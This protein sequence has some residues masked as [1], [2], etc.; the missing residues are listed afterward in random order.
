M[1]AQTRM[2]H[3]RRGF[4][5][6]EL[7][8]TLALVGIVAIGAFS[9][10]GSVSTVFS[11]Q[12][13]VTDAQGNLR[14]ALDVIQDDAKSAGYLGTANMAREVS[15]VSN[16]DGIC[17]N[18]TGLSM[19]RISAVRI[20]N[21][22]PGAYVFS[23][24]DNV[25]IEPDS[26]TL[27]GAFS[28]AEALPIATVVN[29]TLNLDP[30]EATRIFSGPTAAAN[31]AIFT[32][33]FRPRRLVRVWKPG[34]PAQLTFIVSAA[35]QDGGNPVVQLNNLVTSGNAQCGTEGVAA[36]GYRVSVLEIVRYHLVEDPSDERKANLMRTELDPTTG[37]TLSIRIGNSDFPNSVAVAEYVVDFQVW[38]D[39]DV[40]SD[41][42]A[43]VLP[44]IGPD[45]IGDDEGGLRFDYLEGGLP[46]QDHWHRVRVLHI[47][48]AVRT[49]REDPRWLHRQRERQSG[50]NDGIVYGTLFSV[51]LNDNNVGAARVVSMTTSVEVS[52]LTFRNL[53]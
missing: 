35:W 51:N 44:V 38:A 8:V 2:R 11:V 3:D 27:V 12:Q 45:K 21:D 31:Q 52:N 15:T 37:N 13:Q 36:Q 43:D 17:P 22:D 16:E 49:P 10:M 4:T 6:I 14:F 25:N 30:A 26:L 24:F 32:N 5:L 7:L 46:S 40:R 47:Q 48:L 29:S 53:Q 19:D 18:P 23:D 39:G 34:A 41:V 33:L 28:Q 50:S 1:G 9:F 42:A 20:E